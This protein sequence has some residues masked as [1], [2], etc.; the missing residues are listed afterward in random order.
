[1]KASLTKD[2]VLVIA[3][4]A[5]IY[6]LWGSTYVVIKIGIA[7]FP[8]LLFSGSRFTLT[9]IILLIY[10]LIKGH[11]LPNNK[12][13]LIHHSIIGVLLLFGGNGLLAYGVQWVDS[14]I[15]SL[16]IACVPLFMALIEFFII[17]ND[18]LHFTGW[19]GLFIGFCGVALLV[20]PG[21][22]HSSINVTGV[23]IIILAAF[24]WACGSVYSKTSVYSGPMVGG[25][26][27][28]MLAG[29]IAL[30]IFSISRGE[31]TRFSISPGSLLAILYLI[32]FGSLIGYFSYLFL[33]QKCSAARVGTYAYVNPPIAILLGN[34]ILKEPITPNILLSGLVILLGVLLV[35]TSKYKKHY[36]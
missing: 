15:A 17:K 12:N 10:A 9:G 16:L 14:G 34:L 36:D 4:F 3:A 32:I 26:T 30:L 27:V 29:G 5:A 24:L 22:D 21:A 23:L 19:L 1:M 7:H 8:P 13:D 18:R 35:Q 31:L 28:Q 2:Q 20:I 33:L 6:F 11:P 25:V